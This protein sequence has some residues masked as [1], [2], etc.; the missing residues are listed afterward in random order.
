MID[1]PISGKHPG[2]N[3]S[4][5]AM[6]ADPMSP[7]P[8]IALVIK[9]KNHGSRLEPFF[10]AIRALEPICS[11]ELILVDNGSTDDTAA[12]L[13][14]FAGDFDG[15]VKV[16]TEWRPGTGL[17]CNTGW[18][19]ASAPLIALTDD[20]CYPA[21]DYLRQILAVFEDPSLGFAGGRV[22]LFDPTDAPVTI[23]ESQTEQ[24]LKPGTFVHAGF[25]QGANMVLRREVL[26][27]TNGF[28]DDFRAG[29]DIDL[30]LRALASGWKGK[31]DPRLMVYHHHRRKPG[32]DIEMLERSYDVGRG[33]YHMKC[34]LF[35]PQRWQC[36]WHWMRCIRRQPIARTLREFRSA[37]QY[38]FHQFKHKPNRSY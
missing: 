7:V 12:R 18:R 20:D 23:N 4:V 34:L 13:N 11:W 3:A 15:V 5:D 22:L 21:P 16:I 31:H 1:Q 10:A 32:P 8:A 19:A 2:R 38:F 36:A 33:R 29:E 24:F 17:A 14:A 28:D 37:I 30:A 26:E 6:S 27:K 35:M 9:T 25:L